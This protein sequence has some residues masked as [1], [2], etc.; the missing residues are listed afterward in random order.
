[1]LADVLALVE[2]LVLAEVLALVEALVLALVLF[3]S[4]ERFLLTSVLFT[5]VY[6]MFVNFQSNSL[7]SLLLPSKFLRVANSILLFPFFVEK[8]LAPSK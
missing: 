5:S 6:L 1:M 8:N 4:S 3:H 2:A 7:N